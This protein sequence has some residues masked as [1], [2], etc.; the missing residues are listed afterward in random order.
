M[1]GPLAGGI[2]QEL[3]SRYVDS[4]PDDVYFR[5][6]DSVNQIDC[7]MRLDPREE[8]HRVVV[9]ASQRQ[10]SLIAITTGGQR[11][12]RVASLCG[13]NGLVHLPSLKNDG[14]TQIKRGE[15]AQAVMIGEIKGESFVHQ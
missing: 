8:F 13:A 4:K 12:S 2:C 9:S 14:V 7:D 5:S 1:V 15:I 6:S 3:E 11:S 10:G